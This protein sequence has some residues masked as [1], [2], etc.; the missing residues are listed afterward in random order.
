MFC[1]C[2]PVSG[3]FW[4]FIGNPSQI[5]QGPLGRHIMCGSPLSGTSMLRDK[6][7]HH[8]E[9][10]K[11]RCFLAFRRN[12]RIFPGFPRGANWISSI[13]SR[14]P[15]GFLRIPPKRP[16]IESGGWG[17]AL[18]PERHGLRELGPGADFFP[19]P[20]PLFFSPAPSREGFGCLSPGFWVFSADARGMGEFPERNLGVERISISNSG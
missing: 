15:R 5:N 2:G 20:P 11:S 17:A 4:E 12:K 3:W 16:P 18:R 7:L 13:H 1:F 19:S 9:A 14:T 8:F 6:I 10:V